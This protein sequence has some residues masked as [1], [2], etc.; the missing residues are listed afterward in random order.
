MPLYRTATIGDGSEVNPF[1]S[2][3]QEPGYALLDIRD[4]VKMPGEVLLWL[5]TPS[6]D[7]RLTKLADDPTER[8]S[9]ASKQ[10]MESRSS[11]TLARRADVGTMLA[12]LFT[13]HSDPQRRRP[14]KASKARSQLEV[15]VAGRLVWSQRVARGKATQTLTETWPSTG[16]TITSGQDQV[17]AVESGTFNVPSAGTIRSNAAGTA[18]IAILGAA[19]NMDT[20]DHEITSTYALVSAAANNDLDLR[21]RRDSVGSSH[22]RIF[23][24]RNSGGHARQVTRR[25]TGT[26]T[27][28][29]SDTTDP[30]TGAEVGI[31][32]DG[33]A[34][35]AWATGG[36]FSAPTFGP[37]TDTA[38]TGHLTQGFSI[39]PYA[40]GADGA[41]LSG[42]MT[43][44]DIVAGTLLLMMSEYGD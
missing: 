30:S 18:A 43:L 40:T 36:S 4:D 19:N 39:T 31:R 9:V 26:N 1:C 37:I 17:W 2:S 5:P 25:D 44:R 42:T 41:E 16:T 24:R 3:V 15:W 27:T 11:L 13:D 23:L 7:A 6:G 22:Y 20:D 10:V 12:A 8:L 33:S 34:I 38:V 32:A 14:L 21:V 29:A 28:I 35:T